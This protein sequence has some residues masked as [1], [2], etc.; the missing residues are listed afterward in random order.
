MT[1]RKNREENEKQGALKEFEETVKPDILEE[2]Q[3]DMLI[4]RLMNRNY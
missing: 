1:A 4:S 3:A 2:I